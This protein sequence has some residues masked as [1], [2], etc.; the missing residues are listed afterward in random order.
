MT[1]DSLFSSMTIRTAK[2]H[3]AWQISSLCQQLDYPITPEQ[4]AERIL[5]IE[6]L[7]E[8]IIFVAEH[9]DGFLLGLVQVCVRHL[10]VTGVRAEIEGLVVGGDYRRS[11]VGSALMLRAEEWARDQGCKTVYLRSNVQRDGARQF[12]EAIGY[13]VIKSQW[14]FQKTLRKV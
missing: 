2:G 7:E 4:A 11:G 5:Q 3:D 10:L 8:N 14:A 6:D 1:D 9:S 12:Y 13:E